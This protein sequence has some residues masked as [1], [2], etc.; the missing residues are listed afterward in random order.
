MGRHSSITNK[1]YTKQEL[2]EQ[3]RNYV[4][5]TG[6]IPTLKSIYADEA[7]ANP[8]TFIRYFGTWNNA[9]KEAGIA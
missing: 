4:R 8:K 5:R 6:K 7:S 1:K 3:L 9:L 2:A